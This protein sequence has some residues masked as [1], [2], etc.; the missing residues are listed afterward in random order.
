VK[1][2]LL[3]DEKR[4][5]KEEERRDISISLCSDFLLIFTVVH[6]S[7]CYNPN[8]KVKTLKKEK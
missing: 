3:F 1:N 8:K 6:F 4:R 5:K 7:Q 2:F